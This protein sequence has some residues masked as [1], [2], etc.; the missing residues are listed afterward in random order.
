MQND[1]ETQAVEAVEP[2]PTAPH[3]RNAAAVNVASRRS[4]LRESRPCQTGSQEE[5]VCKSAR[6]K[7]AH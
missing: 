1:T 5:P 3:G 2:R 6:K 4:G 7:L